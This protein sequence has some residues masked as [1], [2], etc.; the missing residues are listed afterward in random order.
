M[1]YLSWCKS[2]Y[3]LTSNYCYWAITSFLNSGYLYSMYLS[4]KKLKN[5]GPSRDRILG[6]RSPC[7]S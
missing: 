4:K 7:P 1:S 3:K 2:L 5:S 6:G